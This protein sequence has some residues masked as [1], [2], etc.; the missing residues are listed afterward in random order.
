MLI[1]ETDG[2]IDTDAPLNEADLDPDPIVEFHRWFALAER[3]DEAQPNAMALAT[4]TPAGRPA[5]RLVLLHR[6]T[7]EGFF[8]F[9][10]YESEKG[11]DLAANPQAALA[12]YWPRLHRQVRVHGPV[13]R[14]SRAV[15]EDYWAHRP[16]GSRVSA[17]ASPQSRPIASRVDLEAEVARLVTA[18]PEAGGGPPLPDFWGGYCVTPEAIEF[19]QG[20]I[21]RLHDRIRYRRAADGWRVKRLAP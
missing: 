15:S 3:V 1:L 2:V 6:A 4:V 7:P 20:R 12:F 13:S 16:Y 21:N 17:A 14:T 18:H 19:W 9:T 5:V 11:Q 8:F 10:N